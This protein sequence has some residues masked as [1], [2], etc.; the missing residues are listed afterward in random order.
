[1]VAQP[2]Q[3]SR[4]HTVEI[5]AIFSFSKAIQKASK[6]KGTLKYFCGTIADSSPEKVK[7]KIRYRGGFLVTRFF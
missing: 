7:N 6:I 4:A 3:Q 2:Q 1:M 5:H